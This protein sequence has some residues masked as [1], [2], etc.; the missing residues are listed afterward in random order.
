MLLFFSFQL[1]KIIR[2]LDSFFFWRLNSHDFKHN[3]DNKKHIREKK[4]S[5][6]GATLIEMVYGYVC[7]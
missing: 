3:V 5:I 6:I 7:L 4:I 2:W 1:C